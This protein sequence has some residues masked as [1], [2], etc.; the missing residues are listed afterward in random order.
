L[1]EVRARVAR[2]WREAWAEVTRG[3]SRYC[4]NGLRANWARAGRGL[5]G[6]GERARRGSGERWERVW[7][8]VG[9]W[10]SEGSTMLRAGWEVERSLRNGVAKRAEKELGEGLARAE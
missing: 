1:R 5:G 9:R 10:L 6:G 8:K 2:R 4:D 3:L 7:E